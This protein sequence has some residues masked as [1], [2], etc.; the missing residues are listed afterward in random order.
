MTYIQP[1]FGV[2]VLIVFP[3]QHVAECFD[4]VFSQDMPR[5]S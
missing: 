3:C 2:D 1:V 5:V 4:A